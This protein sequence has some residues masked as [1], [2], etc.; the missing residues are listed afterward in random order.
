MAGMPWRR[1]SFSAAFAVNLKG[2]GLRAWPGVRKRRH[3]MTTEGG[4]SGAVDR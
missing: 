4:F 2:A 1:N 3:Y